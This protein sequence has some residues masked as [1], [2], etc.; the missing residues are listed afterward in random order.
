MAMANHGRSAFA[1]DARKIA[2]G[3]ANEAL[4]LVL[5]VVFGGFVNDLGDAK[6]FAADH[7]SCL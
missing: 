4:K 5:L 6:E 2:K 7:F 1:R 3:L